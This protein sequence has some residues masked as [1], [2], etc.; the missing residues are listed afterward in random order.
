M[1]KDLGSR[2]M[3]KIN[4]VTLVLSSAIVLAFVVP[5]ENPPSKKP[6]LDYRIQLDVIS[7]GFDGESSWF[8][9]RSAA[10][11]GKIPTIVFTM[12]K[13]MVTRSDVFFPLWLTYSNDLGKTW[14]R[15][16]EQPNSLG[17]RLE[18]GG[19]EVGISDFT[20]KWHAKTG[21]VLG[22]G[23]TVRYFDNRLIA[24]SA[25]QTIFSV[26]DCSSHTWAPWS[27]LKLPDDP[28]FY[29]EG[30]GSTQRVDLPGGDIL[31]PVYHKKKG[32][33][34]YSASVFLC[35]F[36]GKT[37]VFKKQGNE[38]VL[39]RDRGFVEPSITVYKNR[40]FLT[41]R[42][43]ESAHVAVSADGLHFNK[44]KEWRFDTG[45]VLGSY[46]TQ[47][48]WVTHSDGLYLVYTSKRED[49]NNVARNRAPLFIA[50]V[51]PGKLEVIKSTERVLV[52]NK[53]AQ[54]GNF[55]VMNLNEKE[56]WVT[57]S[58]GM[59]NGTAYGA[60]NRVYAARIIWNKPNKSWN[61]Q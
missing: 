57:T 12:Q 1:D 5:K 2:K 18:T 31:L 32:T 4:L 29:S 55:G 10:I 52:P 51:D 20:P 25:R 11:P 22:T 26:Y 16:T 13:W 58:E 59:S 17:R 35:S 33:E 53:G 34:I 39:P 44:P 30:A 15:I 6:D 38:I 7:S 3:I 9:P 42:S 48:H 50:R 41:L 14:S 54:L 8:H 49:N 27:A 45:E 28:K 47:Q 21:T 37:L 23:H 60:D 46:N 24:G 61:K 40:Y 19:V 43:N 56:T 36:D